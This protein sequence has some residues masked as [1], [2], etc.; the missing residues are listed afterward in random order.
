MV[1]A[2]ADSLEALGR[3]FIPWQSAVDFEILPAMTDEEAHAVAREMV[4]K[5]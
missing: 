2:E 4:A 3:W 5:G 1:V